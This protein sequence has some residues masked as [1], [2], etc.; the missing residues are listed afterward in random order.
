MQQGSKNRSMAANNVLYTAE[1][2]YIVF[3][4]IDDKQQL[5]NCALVNRIWAAEAVYVLWEE[6]PWAAV[7]NLTAD[8]FHSYVDKIRK[9]T[10]KPSFH[11]TSLLDSIST[12]SGFRGLRKLEL[13][14]CEWTV[15]ECRLLS[16]NSVSRLF[17]PNLRD[18]TLSG[19]IVS[20]LT[21]HVCAHL[22]VGRVLISPAS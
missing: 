15:D 20:A 10:F 5:F 8:R 2:L 21:Q 19:G 9:L 6:A 13:I 17:N 12:Q 1:Y 22:K 4:F 3:S 16:Y 11:N 7:R 18:L 14:G